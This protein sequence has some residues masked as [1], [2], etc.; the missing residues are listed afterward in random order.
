MTG[1]QRTAVYPP[2]L[3]GGRAVPPFSFDFSFNAYPL[4]Y[5]RAGPEITVRHLLLS[6]C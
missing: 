5:Q 6:D 4:D 3:S 2:P 1:Y